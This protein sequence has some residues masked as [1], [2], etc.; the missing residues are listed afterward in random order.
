MR[1]ETIRPLRAG[2]AKALICSVADERFFAVR[3]LIIQP[4]WQRMSL[5]NWDSG[6]RCSIAS[7]V[8]VQRIL[9]QIRQLLLQPDI[10]G[11]R[12]DLKPSRLVAELDVFV[13]Q[14]ALLPVTLHCRECFE[15]LVI[16]LNGT[17][18]QD[19]EY[20]RQEQHALAAPRLRK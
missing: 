19:Q 8:K 20:D 17:G 14:V 5:P 2:R 16:A 1:M 9:L 3:N 13:L 7:C 12:V 6:I 10:V 11:P 15:L 18:K 4:K